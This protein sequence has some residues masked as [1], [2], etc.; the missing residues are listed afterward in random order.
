MRNLQA[1]KTKERNKKLSEI[2]EKFKSNKKI[3]LPSSILYVLLGCCLINIIIQLIN[4]LMMVKSQTNSEQKASFVNEQLILY[5]MSNLLTILFAIITFLAKS[6]L[7]IG[8]FYVIF[9][10][11]LWVCSSIIPYVFFNDN[12]IGL[13]NIVM[14]IVS[15]SITLDLFVV[16]Y[17]IFKH[18]EKLKHQYYQN[19]LKTL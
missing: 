17:L 8:N 16:Y 6:K 7:K 11:A 18:R 12:P 3:N 15:I 2:F 13:L 19:K 1:I 5:V 10:A 9:W 14:I 4:F